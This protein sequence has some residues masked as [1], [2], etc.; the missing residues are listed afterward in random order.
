M[1]QHE[2]PRANRPE[3]DPRKHVPKGVVSFAAFLVGAAALGGVLGLI[4]QRNREGVTAQA[5][6]QAMTGR[7][8]HVRSAGLGASDAA[9]GAL[10]GAP[11][12]STTSGGLP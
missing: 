8:G 11:L 1:K 6:T 2:N 7:A 9:E 10:P 12:P 5:A 3:F 4:Q